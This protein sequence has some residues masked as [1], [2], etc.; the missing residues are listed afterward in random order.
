MF[1]T[2]LDAYCL[3]LIPLLKELVSVQ[4]SSLRMIFFLFIA[5]ALW[6]NFLVQ[7][8]EDAYLAFPSSKLEARINAWFSDN[9]STRVFLVVYAARIIVV[10]FLTCVCVF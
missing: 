3:K 2:D 8:G 1:R 10:L 6:L 4:L 7:P 5:C 9:V